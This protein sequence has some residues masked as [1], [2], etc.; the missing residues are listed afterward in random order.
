M[1]TF[2]EELNVFSCTGDFVYFHT[3]EGLDG[4]GSHFKSIKIRDDLAKRGTFDIYV[5]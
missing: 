2:T 3:G 1:E 5:S 4:D